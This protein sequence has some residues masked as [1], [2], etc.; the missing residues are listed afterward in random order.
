M[1]PIYSKVTILNLCPAYLNKSAKSNKSRKSFKIG[2][3]FISFEAQLNYFLEYLW[4]LI[5]FLAF[6]DIFSPLE[7][8]QKNIWSITKKIDFKDEWLNKLQLLFK[9]CYSLAK[10]V[11]GKTR[12]TFS[13]TLSDIFSRQCFFVQNAYE[14]FF[15]QIIFVSFGSELLRIC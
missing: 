7:E 1:V 5:T 11:A 6:D 9:G 8:D 4:K 2:F 14:V 10:D 3:C 12:K 13:G 15:S